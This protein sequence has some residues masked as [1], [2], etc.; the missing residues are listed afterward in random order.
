MPGWAEDGPPPYSRKDLLPSSSTLGKPW[1]QETRGAHWLDM[2]FFSSNNLYSCG[3]TLH[4]VNSMK[5]GSGWFAFVS[6]WHSACM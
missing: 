5:V 4:Y 6:S 3:Y 2:L 1:P